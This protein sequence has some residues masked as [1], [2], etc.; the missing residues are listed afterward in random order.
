MT[1][2]LVERD[3]TFHMCQACSLLLV[4]PALEEKIGYR[5]DGNF[6]AMSDNLLYIA[7]PTDA[8]VFGCQLSAGSF[9]EL[10]TPLYAMDSSQHCVFYS[11]KRDEVGIDRCCRVDFISQTQDEA[12]ALDDTYVVTSVLKPP[13]L[14]ISCLA[15]ASCV[16]LKVPLQVIELRPG[17]EVFTSNMLI[18][19]MNNMQIMMGDPDSNGNTGLAA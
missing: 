1:F 5:L 10:G 11:Y 14:H 13:K 18:T 16:Q 7:C 12:M 3:G 6:M 8:E 15:T 4:H 9:C 2:P 17:C 19:P